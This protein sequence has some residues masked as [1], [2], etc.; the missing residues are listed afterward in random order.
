MIIWVKEERK[1][2]NSNS[3]TRLLPSTIIALLYSI[4]FLDPRFIAESTLELA[5]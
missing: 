3:I 4:S 1:K 5:M 2:R